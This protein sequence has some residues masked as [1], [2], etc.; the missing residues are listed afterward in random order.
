MFALA[1]LPNP[2]VYAMTFIAAWMWAA[3]YRRRPNLF[4][5]ALSHALL[6]AV[7]VTALPDWFTAH[8]RV[9]PGYWHHAPG[10]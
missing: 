10:R 8:L 7:V 3:F 9:G 2:G 5:L 4:V 1:H 6:A